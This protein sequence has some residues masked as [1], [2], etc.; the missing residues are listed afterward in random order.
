MIT[1][2]IGMLGMIEIGV[3]EKERV[4]EIDLEI[5]I[6]TVERERSG[7]EIEMEE[8]ETETEI[9]EDRTTVRKRRT[10]ALEEG[11]VEIENRKI[12]KRV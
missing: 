9:I 8:T 12:A 5:E 3:V 1:V 7:V 11:R 2:V 10:M 6:E 4:G